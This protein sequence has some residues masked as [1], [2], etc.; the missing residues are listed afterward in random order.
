MFRKYHNQNAF[1]CL[2]GAR[3]G[4]ICLL[5]YLPFS[6]IVSNRV[7]HLEKRVQVKTFPSQNAPPRIGQ[8]VPKYEKKDWSKRPHKTPPFFKGDFSKKY[9]ILTEKMLF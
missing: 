5:C 6:K 8:N 1:P 3:Q 4:E 9:G 7:K 2:R